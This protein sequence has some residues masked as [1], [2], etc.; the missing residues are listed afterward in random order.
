MSEQRELNPYAAPKEGHKSAKRT[1]KKARSG[2][3]DEDTIQQIVRSFQKTR[4]WIAF[5]GV[6]S[7]IG[8]V[9]A[10]IGGAFVAFMSTQARGPFAALGPGVLLI[11]LVLAVVYVV[12]GARLL[13]YRDAIDDVIRSEGQIEHIGNAIERQAQFW[14]LAGQT[15]VALLI[16]YGIVAIV[17]AAV[18]VASIR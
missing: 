10:A 13:R 2:N 14:S 17:G 7:Y 18:G 4:S 3:D 8:A 16:L 1:K 15:F 5:F 9:I 12:F 11:Y 6:L